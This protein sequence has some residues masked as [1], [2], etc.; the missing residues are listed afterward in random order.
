MRMRQRDGAAVHIPIL[1]DAAENAIKSSPS[2][3]SRWGF[4]VPKPR[5]VNTMLPGSAF[6]M[7]GNP[8]GKGGVTMRWMSALGVLILAGSA[9][10]QQNEAEKLFR[11]ME[12]KVREA[13]AIKIVYE[14]DETVDKGINKYRGA[15]TIAEGNRVRIEATSTVGGK[16]N[17][18]TV[19]ADGKQAHSTSTDNPKANLSPVESNTSQTEPQILARGGVLLWFANGPDKE[20][21]DIDKMMPISD[22]KLGKKEKVG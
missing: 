8:R 5:R 1:A 12:K 7:N 20:T 10:A 17:T 6:R 2:A 21:F 16:Q 22:F 4:P 15:V 13:K 11:A 18:K 3:Q 14:I 9:F 19:V